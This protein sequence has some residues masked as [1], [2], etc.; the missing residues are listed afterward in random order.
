M[1]YTG[2]V[3]IRYGVCSSEGLADFFI[4]L[5]LKGKYAQK[6]PPLQPVEIANIIFYLDRRL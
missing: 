2:F 5:R 4:A 1:Q 3:T 6:I